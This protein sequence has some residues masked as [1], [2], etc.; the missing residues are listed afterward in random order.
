MNLCNGLR[1]GQSQPST[2][3]CTARRVRAIKTLKDVWH[4]FRRN[5]VAGVPNGYPESAIARHRR[6]K[7]ITAWARV[8]NRVVQ[9]NQD[10]APDAGLVG[11]SD[12]SGRIVLGPY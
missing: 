1:N 4:V 7:H 12:R 2:L 11:Q 6:E 5:P 8:F 10:Q 3:M 9:Q